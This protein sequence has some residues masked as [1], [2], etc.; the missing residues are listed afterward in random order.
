ME[1]GEAFNGGRELPK[2]R[3]GAPKGEQGYK[4]RKDVTGEEY[5]VFTKTVSNLSSHP[6]HTH[7]NWHILSAFW[8]VFYF[9]VKKKKKKSVTVQNIQSAILNDFIIIVQDGIRMQTCTVLIVIRS[10]IILMLLFRKEWRILVSI[11]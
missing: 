3:K 8:Q 5:K 7:N 10:M 6:C 4:G 11:S 1:G 9:T 2:G